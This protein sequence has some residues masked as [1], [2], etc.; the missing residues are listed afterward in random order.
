MG[1]IQL[2]QFKVKKIGAQ[3]HAV[4]FYKVAQLEDWT[5]GNDWTNTHET[6]TER[7]KER[8]RKRETETEREAGL[9]HRPT[10]VHHFPGAL[11]KFHFCVISQV[12]CVLFT[13]MVTKSV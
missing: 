13:F 12:S 4:A 3:R 9:R 7:E 1:F 5:S 10:V 2:P 11:G 6:E 8:G